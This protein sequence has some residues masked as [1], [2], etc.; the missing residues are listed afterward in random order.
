MTTSER[1]SQYVLG[2]YG[3]FP[4]VPVKA[5][6][7]WM[8]SEDGK[9]YL[10]FCCGIAVC[11]IGHSHP[12]LV[13]AIQTQASQLIHCSNLYQIPQQAELAELIVEKCVGI[14]GKMFFS[15]SGAEANDGLIKL[16]RRF[17]QASATATSAAR[18]EIISFNKSFHGRTLGTIAATGQKK[19]KEGFD[20]LLPGFKH[21]PFNDS[22]A[23]KEAVGE[24]TVAIL[25]EPLQ[26]EGGISPVTPLFLQTISELREKHNLLVFFDEVQ[27]GFGRLGEMMAWRK[28]MS[29]L[30]PDGISWAKAMGGGFPI[31]GFWVADRTFKK[32]GEDVP[33]SSILG[34]GSHGSTYGG[35]PLA[36]AA[37]IAVLSEILEKDL[38]ANALRQEERIRAVAKTWTLPVLAELKGA[39]LMLG[40]KL[41]TTNFD[42]PEGQTHAL[43]ICLKLMEAG[44]LTVPA[45]ADV[46]RWLPPLNVTDGEVDQ[47]L[48]IL[49]SVLE[50]VGFASVG[51]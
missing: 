6:G 22:V 46:V 7:V 17:G 9:R 18:Y 8:T 48:E 24:K 38:P 27:A 40:W 37:S 32:D 45:G 26:G 43:H 35:N 12:R 3:R 19:I 25:L 31:G 10:D 11:S 15:N 29:E 47:A 36:C 50:N 13:E 2:T 16:A 23:L 39:G 51:G 1:F 34:P 5:E 33:L 42:P 14:P 44:L 30:E 28:W 41:N 20:P 21:V 4:M 49:H